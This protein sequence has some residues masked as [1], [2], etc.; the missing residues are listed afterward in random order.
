MKDK[1]DPDLVD[2]WNKKNHQPAYDELMNRH[3]GMVYSQSNKYRASP[4]PQPALESQAW[5]HF[6]DAVK[7]YKPDKGAKF[8]THLNYRLRKLDRYNKTYQN[9]ARIP[10]DLAYK[11]GDHDRVEDNLQQSLGRQPTNKELADGMGEDTSA[12]RRLRKA[13]RQDLYQ[14]QYEGEQ[15]DPDVDTPE[16]QSLIKDIRAELK[17]QEQEVYDH[18]TGENRHTNKT[19]LARKLGM[20]PGRLSQITGSIA[21]KM[22]PHLQ[23]NG[24]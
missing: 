18:L 13:R 19:E 5:Q 16:T 20:S 9:M 21:K 4:V 1:D 17:P 15:D 23:R 11:I 3:E 14:G 6:D 7:T 2:M 22:K 24:L 12:V 8:S 10:E